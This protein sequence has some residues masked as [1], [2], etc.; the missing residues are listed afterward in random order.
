[1]AAATPPASLIQAITRVLT[2]GPVPLEEVVAQ[3]DAAGLLEELRADGVDEEDMAEAVWDELIAVD[4]LWRTAADQLV[5][6]SYLTDGR[7]FTHRLTGAEREAGEV[8][9]CP[10]LLSLDWDEGP[11]LELAAGG[12][13]SVELGPNRPGEDDSVLVGP[14]GWL[15]GFAPGDLLAFTRRDHSVH[16]EVVAPNG[17]GALEIGLLR[18]AVDGHIPPGHGDEALPV[19]LDA[20]AADPEA[21]RRPRP[22]LG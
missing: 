10:D 19:A 12:R 5:S 16:V 2:N 21:F 9:I 15:D 20:L 1:M 13:L 3:L 7:V 11:G 8:A 6:S 17:D 4:G 22:P 14:D 18:H